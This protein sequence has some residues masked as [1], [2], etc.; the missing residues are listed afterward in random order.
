MPTANDTRVRVDGLS[1][2]T[3]TARGPASG[4]RRE[5]VGLHRVGEVEHLGLLGRASGR[6]RAGSAGRHGRRPFASGRSSGGGDGARGVEDRR[7]RGEE[8]VGLRVGEDQRRREPDDVGRDGVDEEA[9]LAG[10]RLDRRPR[11]AR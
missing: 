5:P 3:A 4:C 7:Q 6:R 10:G 1:K 8:G 11:P 9:G 2:T